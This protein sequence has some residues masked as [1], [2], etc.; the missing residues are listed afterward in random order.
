MLGYRIKNRREAIKMTQVALAEAVG[1]SGAL[2]TYYEQGLK[3]PSAA[4]LCKI[5]DALD[6]STDFL[7]GRKEA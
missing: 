5:A 2:V 1:I 6:C 3:V 7:L 4:T